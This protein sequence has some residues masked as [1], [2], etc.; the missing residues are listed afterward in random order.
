MVTN[1]IFW[2]STLRHR[3]SAARMMPQLKSLCLQSV[4]R[5]KQKHFEQPSGFFRDNP[6]VDGMQVSHLRPVTNA[7]QAH[8][9]LLS[10]EICS[11]A[12]EA[13]IEPSKLQLQRSQRG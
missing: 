4:L 11:L 3:I 13:G 6:N 9:P 10:Q 1:S 7:L 8:W 12:F 2:Y 5:S